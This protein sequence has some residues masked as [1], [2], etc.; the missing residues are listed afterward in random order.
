MNSITC[1]SL[2]KDALKKQE[3][4]KKNC[5]RDFF[6]FILFTSVNKCLLIFNLP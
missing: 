6:L 3:D 2:K 1:Y 5:H 4:G